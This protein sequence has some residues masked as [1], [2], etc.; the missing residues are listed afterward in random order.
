M[1]MDSEEPVRALVKTGLPVPPILEEALG[2]G[3]A[4]R[5]FAVFWEATGDELALQDG[6]F[7]LVGGNHSAWFALMLHPL[8]RLVAGH[9]N[10]GYSEEQA[11]HCLVVDRKER[12]IY[13]ADLED[14]SAFLSTANEEFEAA[15]KTRRSKMAFDFDGLS[16]KIQRAESAI[17]KLRD[18]LNN[19]MERLLREPGMLLVASAPEARCIKCGCTDGKACMT[20]EGPCHWIWV[21][22]ATGR[23]LCSGCRSTD[24]SPIGGQ[25]LIILPDGRHP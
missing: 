1:A 23:G 2:Y 7:L 24:L 17:S 14:A 18:W 16:E 13:A 9:F 22:R 12:Q 21:D 25:P 8:Y 11:S 19:E 3:G 10:F 5:Y 20:L 15:F 4:R 6:E